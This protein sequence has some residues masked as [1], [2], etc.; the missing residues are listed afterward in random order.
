[1]KPQASVGNLFPKWDRRYFALE[2]STLSYYK[3]QED[4]QDM[5]PA[6]DIEIEGALIDES[7]GKGP[8]NSFAILTA[9]RVL[10][11]RTLVKGPRGKAEKMDWIALL[12]RAGAQHSQGA[13][14]SQGL[15]KE[16]DQAIG[17]DYDAFDGDVDQ[18][19]GSGDT[20][21]RT[22]DSPSAA[23]VGSGWNE[24]PEA[25]QGPLN[26]LAWCPGWYTRLCCWRPQSTERATAAG[27]ALANEE[28]GGRTVRKRAPHDD[29]RVGGQATLI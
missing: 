22:R 9:E 7:V 10:L 1:M 4:Y 14:T 27:S 12:M 2:G 25:W 16:V 15:G 13:L 5:K 26:V 11:L 3:D 8:T 18:L 21:S 20:G 28:R 6:G 17:D 19:A 29:R 24:T 23:R